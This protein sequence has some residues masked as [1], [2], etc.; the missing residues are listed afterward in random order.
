MNQDF[1]NDYAREW[2]ERLRDGKNIVHTYLE[3]PAFLKTIGDVTG[4]KI[5]CVGC[6][7]GDECMELKN[8]G[9]E[10]VVGVDLSPEFI[11][12]AKESFPTLEF[13]QMDMENLDFPEKSFDLVVSSLTIHY[14]SNWEKTFGEIRKI[15]KDDGKAVISTNHP[16]RFGSEIK[17]EKEREIFLLGYIR[18]KDPQLFGD[19]IG[20]Y[21]NSRRI[22]DVWFRNKFPVSYYHK[23]ISEMLKEIR[24]SKF[25]L[26][27]FLE[28]KPEPWVK[29]KDPSFYNIHSKIPL[30]IIFELK[31]K[32]N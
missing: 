11:K 13:H 27:N 8:A 20:D 32:L 30:F 6:G 29:E 15:L 4:K 2:T 26:T 7:S 22:D 24:E 21:L 25:E 1:Y 19:V 12:I 18:Y 5:L 14:A 3:K 17:R 31:K 10:H 9:A 23:P 16:I 28:P